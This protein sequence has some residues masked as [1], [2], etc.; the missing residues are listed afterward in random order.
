MSPS[1]SVGIVGGGLAGLA[2][3][4]ALAQRGI[5]VELFE[6][7]GRLGGRASSF[8]DPTTGETVDHCQH[9]G[10]GCCT[11]LADFC[12]RTGI[13]DMFR[14]DEVLHFVGPDNRIYPFAASRV[15]PAPL[16]L[17]TALWQLRYFSVTERVAI[18]RGMWRLMRTADAGRAQSSSFAQW[19][20]GSRQP[21]AAIQNFWNVVVTSALGEVPDRVTYGAA[22]KVFVDGFL[23]SRAAMSVEV[24]RAPLADI[25]GERLATW[26]SGHGVR[27]HCGSAV[28]Q[29][30]RCGQRGWRLHLVD[31]DPV[32]FP[33][34]IVAVPWRRAADLFEPE[35]LTKLPELTAAR[36]IAP[37][38]ITAVHLRFDRPITELPHAVIVGRLSQWMF[39]HGR[40]VE[41]GQ[42][43]PAWAI[44]IV[45]SASHSLTGRDR[46]EIVAEV[47]EDLKAI[48][49]QARGAALLH[50]RVVT[51]PH[52]VFS[53]SH[54][55]ESLRPEQRT[56]LESLA[57][58]GDWTATGWPAT[59]EGAVRSGYRAAEVVMESLGRR[60]QFAVPDLPRGRL[61]KWLVRN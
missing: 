3:A 6:A 9:V 56:A 8:R 29:I 22:R 21:P 17:A 23:S 28:R 42:R 45:I 25:Y 32:S 48:W 31:G 37:A 24:P 15:L 26:L 30:E 7:R 44:Q 33:S 34:L 36:D 40:Q 58:A 60:E 35:L 61:A 5:A 14:R 57:L 12:R 38:P 51:D 27:L 49:S 4:S 1:A 43:H 55:C 53:M 52:A 20:R 2:A 41:D 13:A 11:N 19:L 39:N 46:N 50:A 47:C 54:R 59:M 10:M 16:H 18:A